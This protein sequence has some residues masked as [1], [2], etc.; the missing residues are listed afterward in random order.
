MAILC[1][2]AFI[3]VRQPLFGAAFPYLAPIPACAV[4]GKA[5]FATPVFGAKTAGKT[6]A[7][8]A[9]FFLHLCILPL[10]YFLKLL[11]LFNAVLIPL[12]DFVFQPFAREILANSAEFC[13]MTFAAGEDLTALFPER[14]ASSLLAQTAFAFAVCKMLAVCAVSS[15]GGDF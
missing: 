15:A 5:A 9:Q 12:C 10:V 3:A 14:Y 4:V 7:G 13:V 6:A 11:K 2:T 1:F 8:Y